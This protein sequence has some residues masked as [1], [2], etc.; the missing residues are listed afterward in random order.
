METP[1]LGLGGQVRKGEA[2]RAGRWAVGGR[3]GRMPG[4]PWENHGEKTIR[5]GGKKLRKGQRKSSVD[6][7]PPLEMRPLLLM[8]LWPPHHHQHLHH[9]MVHSRSQ[10][11]GSQPALWGTTGPSPPTFTPSTTSHR[12]AV[13]PSQPVPG[14]VTRTT[15]NCSEPSSPLSKE[16]SG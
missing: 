11:P 12:L 5:I 9:C 6:L 7:L 3:Q 15:H 4:W 1:F 16:G 10:G 14:T 13:P 8:Q 2:E